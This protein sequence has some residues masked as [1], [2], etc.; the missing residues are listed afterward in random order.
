MA[1]GN[2]VTVRGVL[3][4]DPELRISPTVAALPDSV[5]IRVLEGQ[6]HWRT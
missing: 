2:N 5:N 1:N 3:G 4:R 6:D